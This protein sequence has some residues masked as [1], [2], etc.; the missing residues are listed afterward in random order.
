[1]EAL[2][3]AQ[4]KQ[5]NDGELEAKPYNYENYS[6]EVTEPVN[7]IL[8]DRMPIGRTEWGS[9]KIWTISDDFDTRKMKALA[10]SKDTSS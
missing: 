4:L 1:M 3:E 10:V 8:S 5:G 2:C 7:M 6:Q 9:F